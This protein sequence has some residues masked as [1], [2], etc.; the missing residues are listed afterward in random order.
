MHYAQ[1]SKKTMTK[2]SINDL[3]FALLAA[4]I[5]AYD[6][7]ETEDNGTCNFDSPILILEKEWSDKDIREAFNGTGL[8]YLREKDTVEI[9]NATDG[10]GYRRTAMAEAFCESL[11]A[12]GY[13]AGV[14]Y[15]MD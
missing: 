11:R 9:Y 2:K 13:N 14:D 7:I 12:S 6:L 4:K 1:R 3:H 5:K 10:Q 8:Q 15:R